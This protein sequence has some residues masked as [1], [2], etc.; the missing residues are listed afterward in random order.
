VVANIQHDLGAELRAALDQ[1]LGG[2]LL[3]Q[4]LNLL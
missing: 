3:T 4:A 2:L 1:E